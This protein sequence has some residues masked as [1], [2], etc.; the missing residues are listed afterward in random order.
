MLLIPAVD[1]KD[2][3]CVRLRQ[4]RMQD[5]TVFSTDPVSVAQH[6]LELGAR[7]LHVVDLDGAFAGKPFIADLVKQI[8]TAVGDIPVQVGGG[9]RSIESIE[10]YL[11]VGVAD[12]ILGTRAV[13]DPGFLR[14]ACMA[15]PNQIFLGLDARN[16]MIA[17]DGWDKTSALSAVQFAESVSDLALSG[18]VYTDIER[19]GMLTGLNIPATIKLSESS[20]VP[21]VA[22]GGVKSIE[23]LQ[24]LADA[25]LKTSAN[26]LGVITGRALYE[27][28][29]HL[30]EGQA[31]LDRAFPGSFPRS[32]PRSFQ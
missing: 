28:T 5:V 7:R 17:T 16:G 12:V 23:H 20:A 27:Q 4:G 8:C 32:F 9:I 6:W 31:L 22:S 15:F 24:A 11:G 26:I 14:E 21:V 13:Q 1:I 10:A 3:E 29:L 30:P 19:D 2:G 18:I 25:A